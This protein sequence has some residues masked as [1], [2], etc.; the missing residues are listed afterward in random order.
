MVVGRGAAAG[1][2]QG[3]PEHDQAVLFPEIEMADPE[4]LVYLGDELNHLAA[5]KRRNLEIEGAGEMQRLDVVHPRERELVFGPVAAHHQ[6]DFIVARA[7]ERPIATGGQ[8]LDNVE[9][10]VCASL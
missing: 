3:L 8:A 6:G 1:Q 4:L 2:H 5:A 7:I 10:V 9:R